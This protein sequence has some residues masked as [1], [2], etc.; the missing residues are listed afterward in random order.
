MSIASLKISEAAFTINTKITKLA[1]ESMIG[2]PSLEPAIPT[3]AP[4]E[5]NASE[6][7]CQASAISALESILLA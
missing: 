4:M 1:M 5:E 7:W 2:N 6:R 3:N